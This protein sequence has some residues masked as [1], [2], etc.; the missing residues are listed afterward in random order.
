[1]R[2][3]LYLI[4]PGAMLIALIAFSFLAVSLIRGYDIPRCFYCGASKVRASR[5]MGFLDFAGHLLMIRSYR[6]SGCRARF[7]AIR[8][9]NRSRQHSAF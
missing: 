7:H 1:M 3:L 9:F 4:E 2:Q 6:C 8:L 5:P